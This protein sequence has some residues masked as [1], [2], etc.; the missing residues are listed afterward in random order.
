MM[1][2]P[3]RGGDREGRF[4]LE[5]A[6]A[7][8]RTEAML[9]LKFVASQGWLS[10]VADTVEYLSLFSYQSGSH[11]EE[12]LFEAGPLTI[13]TCRN[14]WIGDQTTRVLVDTVLTKSG[15]GLSLSADMTLESEYRGVGSREQFAMAVGYARFGLVS[16]GLNQ[17]DFH[18]SK[19]GLLVAQRLRKK[20][21]GEAKVLFNVY[22][23]TDRAAEKK[24]AKLIDP[25][26]VETPKPVWYYL[27][28]KAIS[29]ELV[30]KT[31][32]AA[33]RNVEQV[34][35]GQGAAVNQILVVR[36]N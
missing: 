29:G 8:L 2:D 17:I 16:Y 22:S 23:W 11:G 6:P 3:E 12:I 24:L 25:R 19:H 20:G 5:E 13:R 35:V 4:L 36:G 28:A 7:N 27:V 1:A 34:L 14:P 26:V 31:I 15:N 33:V 30:G 32:A 18:Y 10:H 9:A 21:G